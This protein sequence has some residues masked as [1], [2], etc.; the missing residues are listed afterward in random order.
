MQRLGVAMVVKVPKDE[1]DVPPQSPI[2]ADVGYIPDSS[3]RPYLMIFSSELSRYSNILSN[4]SFLGDFDLFE[5]FDLDRDFELFVV[6]LTLIL[7]P[8]LFFYVTF[9]ASLICDLFRF[10]CCKFVF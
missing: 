2:I 4:L 8:F 1:D 5:L 9:L 10:Y 3:F 6:V 7:L